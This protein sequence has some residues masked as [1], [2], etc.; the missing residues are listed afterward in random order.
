MSQ[1]VGKGN[2]PLWSAVALTI[3]EIENA[4][5]KDKKYKL[6]DGGGLCI[7]IQP[8][9]GKVWLWPYRFNGAEK[10]MTFGE[11]PLVGPKD[12]R[13]LHF[14]AKKL[15]A[16]GVNPMAERKAEAE[17]KQQ[18]AKAL[19]RDADSSFEKTVRKWW[20]GGRSANLLVTP[21]RQA[22]LSKTAT[23]YS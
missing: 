8:W 16:S 3:K 9:G 21:N 12:A 14:A 7:L 1:S 4:K 18:E 6:T 10:N 20:E 19:E 2:L 22:P 17:A 5:P 11:Y 15:L 13:E 23:C